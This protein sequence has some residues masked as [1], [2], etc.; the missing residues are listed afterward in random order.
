VKLE[1]KGKDVV[2]SFKLDQT[3]LESL[4]GMAESLGGM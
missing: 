1:S 4:A 3:Q 2:V